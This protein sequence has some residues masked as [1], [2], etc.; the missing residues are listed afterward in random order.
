M[1]EV[2]AYEEVRIINKLMKIPSARKSNV[3]VHS[4]K[5]HFLMFVSV[6]AAISMPLFMSQAVFALDN[7]ADSEAVADGGAP[8]VVPPYAGHSGDGYAYSEEQVVPGGSDYTTSGSYGGNS[9]TSNASAIAPVN[10]PANTNY[11]G[12]G[13]HAATDDSD[14]TADAIANAGIGYSII[15]PITPAELVNGVTYTNTAD[16]EATATGTNGG[17]AYAMA[18]AYVEPAEGVDPTSTATATVTADRGGYAEGSA[19]AEIIYGSVGTATAT[20]TTS[21]DRGW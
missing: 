1:I 6:L 9:A 10:D 14:A 21:A 19:F 2:Y 7:T 8:G 4:M 20:E 16:A 17:D 15:P 12:A 18:N 5:K 13:A 3:E 11:A